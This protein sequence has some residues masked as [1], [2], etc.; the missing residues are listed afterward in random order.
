[1]Y[2]ELGISSLEKLKEA[3]LNHRL[4]GI[5]GF[6]DKTEE[7]ILQGVRTLESKGGRVLLGVALPVAEA[8]VE[9][10]KSSQTLD[11]ISVAGSL[12]RGKETVG[13][14]DILVGDDTPAS[15]MDAFVSYSLV[16]QVIMKGPTKSSVRI[17][18]GLQVDIRAVHT[19]SWGAALCY[20]TGSKEHNVTMRRMGVSMGLKLNEYGL[21]KR[22]SGE[23]VA[24]DTEEGV[25]RALGLS[26]VE[27][28]L[29]EN[30]GELEAAK[31]GRLPDIVRFDQIR[32][33]THSPYELE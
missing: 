18:G 20:F 22:D 26:C 14:I 10:L 32:G 19:N 25:Y 13:D 33:D 23:K 1:M 15:F 5:K 31:E 6:G 30:S 7:R 12:R 17:K 29:R 2:K 4:R 11:M 24:G 28:E 9:F 27:P 21:F 3:A 16:D 8:Y